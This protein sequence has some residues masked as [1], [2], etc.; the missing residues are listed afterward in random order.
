MTDE[1]MRSLEVTAGDA[2]STEGL[3]RGVPSGKEILRF[4][5]AAL[6]AYHTTKESKTC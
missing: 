5:T 4:R 3:L 1:Q 6:T 2:V